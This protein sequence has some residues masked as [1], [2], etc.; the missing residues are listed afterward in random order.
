MKCNGAN[1]D[2]STIDSA[3]QT[4]LKMV[5]DR[6]SLS[7]RPAVETTCVMNWRMRRR[8]TKVSLMSKCHVERFMATHFVWV[9]CDYTVPLVVVG[10]FS[11]GVSGPKR[12]WFT[13]FI[14]ETF[15]LR[16]HNDLAKP[17][18]QCYKC[19]DLTLSTNMSAVASMP[20]SVHH[21]DLSY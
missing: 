2:K 13:H 3:Q 9:S 10:D 14:L 6:P 19:I 16:C 1:L 4:S 8:D 11:V 15:R 12:E 17:T 5:P 20:I 21:Y 7:S 18:C